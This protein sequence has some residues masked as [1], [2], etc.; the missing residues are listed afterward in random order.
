MTN[1]ADPSVDDAPYL[2]TVRWLERAV[3]GLNLC[4]FAKG[5]WVKRQVRIVVS[6]ASDAAGVLQ[7]FQTELLA[8]ADSPPAEVETTLLVTPRA[9]QDFLDFND[10]VGR[11]ERLVRKQGLEGE[12]Q[13]ASFHP[14]YEFADEGPTSITNFTNRSPHPILHLLREASIERAVQAFPDAASIYETNMRT[15]RQLGEA[16]WRALDVGPS[17]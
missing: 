13:V 4:P 3:I 5:P 8:L 11:A 9:L 10:V 1:P 7:D 14:H 16:G 6:G 2:D 12:I 17:A 15:L